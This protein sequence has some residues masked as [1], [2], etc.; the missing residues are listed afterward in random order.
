MLEFQTKRSQLYAYLVIG[1]IVFSFCLI[2]PIDSIAYLF[3]VF[4]GC[5]FLILGILPLFSNQRIIIDKIKNEI[6]FTGGVKRIFI[7]SRPISFSDIDCIEIKESSLV[8]DG[9]WQDMK[10][11]I[12]LKM[13]KGNIVKLGISMSEMYSNEFTHKLSE[14]V[15]CRVICNR[16]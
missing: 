11:T 14:T 10:D 5:I 6:S 3:F 4:I 15:K 12:Y 13:K 9:H 7:R 16:R 2:A 8:T 1:I